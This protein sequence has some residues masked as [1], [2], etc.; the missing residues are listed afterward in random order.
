M[1]LTWAANLEG[2]CAEIERRAPDRTYRSIPTL[3]SGSSRPVGTSCQFEQLHASAPGSLQGEAASRNFRTQAA[4]APAFLAC[5]A[6]D[7]LFAL[8]AGAPGGR[9]TA[10]TRAS[11]FGRPSGP[12]DPSA[13]CSENSLARGFATGS[14]TGGR[15]PDNTEQLLPAVRWQPDSIAVRPTPI[16]I[17]DPTCGWA[18]SEPVALP[19]GETP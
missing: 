18:P 1:V 14:D 7:R 5:G 2:I 17:A 16:P 8:A 3:V 9:R 19:T 4:H 13:A 11:N 12:T 6:K 10:T 15:N